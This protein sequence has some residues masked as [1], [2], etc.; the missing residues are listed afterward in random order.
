[1]DSRKRQRVSR[2]KET[3]GTKLEEAPPELPIGAVVKQEETPPTMPA[4]AVVKQE[5]APPAMPAGAVVQQEEESARQ[6]HKLAQ[7]KQMRCREDRAHSLQLM[8][9][10]R[11]R[12]R[13]GTTVD[14]QWANRKWYRGI[15]VSN[16]SGGLVVHYDDG[17]E[18]RH[19]YA[20][21]AHGTVRVVDVGTP[22]RGRW[23]SSM[24]DAIEQKWSGY[25]V[26]SVRGAIQIYR[27]LVGEGVG[28][29]LAPQAKPLAMPCGIGEE[30]L[31]IWFEGTRFCGSD[32]VQRA[33]QLTSSNAPEVIEDVDGAFAPLR[34]GAQLAEC[35]VDG[36]APNCELAWAPRGEHARWP[37]LVQT[38]DIAP[39]ESIRWLYNDDPTSPMARKVKKWRRG[40]ELEAQRARER[41]T[42]AE[43]RR[44][45]LLTD[46]GRCKDGTFK[47]KS[48]HCSRCG[49]GMVCRC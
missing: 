7:L 48:R 45:Q 23:P 13:V 2:G 46:L 20:E 3:T 38:A 11:H 36:A 30:R 15:V 41:A 26:P 44:R 27:R 14:V 18:E 19:E 32:A 37:V 5:E 21:Y 22:R 42:I 31:L 9:P 33:A 39:G 28:L 10:A 17:D 43:A 6:K 34:L 29:R 1:M 8:A 40:A 12:L 25:R 24:E 35:A 49:R 16:N 47:R 4:G